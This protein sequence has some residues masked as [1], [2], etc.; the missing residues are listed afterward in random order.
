M[1]R[2]WN[3]ILFII[4]AICL[5]ACSK[6]SEQV[7]GDKNFIDSSNFNGSITGELELDP[8]IIY[9]LT[10]GLILEPGATL[11]VPAGTT[12]EAEPGDSYI[13]VKKGA[14]IVI[15]GSIDLP[16]L[17]TTPEGSTNSWGGI[18]IAGNSFSS[19]GENISKTIGKVNFDY[20]GNDLSE[21]SGTIKYL[22]LKNA[23][24]LSNN[25]S[26]ALSLFGVGSGTTIENVAFF[27]SVEGIK[28]TGGTVSSSN[29]YFENNSGSSIVIDEGWSGVQS[30]S[31]V[32]NDKP[33]TSIVSASGPN[34]RPTID[35]FSAR[36][37]QSALG[38][39]F[40]GDSGANITDLSMVGFAP[41]FMLTDNVETV[42]V[43]VEGQNVN[44]DEDY[45]KASKVNRASFNWAGNLIQL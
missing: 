6:N 15:N 33:Y 7:Q 22:I 13:L 31:Y 27:N 4:C 26:A 32:A 29:I 21:N 2:N 8:S 34:G 24:G 19:K 17:M 1:S 39:S 10:G 44:T 3:S 42:N 9:N 5:N 20:G 14:D 23:G 18:L 36:T 43:L 41:S 40:G 30:Y 25:N 45:S 12:I 16:V 35:K 11:I 28:Y 38:F 37:D